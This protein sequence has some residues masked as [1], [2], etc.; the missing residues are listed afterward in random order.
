MQMQADKPN[1]PSIPAINLED[2]NL[3]NNV[4]FHSIHKNRRSTIAL[5][6]NTLTHS[7]AHKVKC[8]TEYKI[9]KLN[10]IYKQKKDCNSKG[11]SSDTEA[12]AILVGVV[13][14]LDRPG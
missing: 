11:L 14:F 8:Q 9:C 12:F 3:D 1:V 5:I 4:Q 10:L 13:E 7:K 6:R 2:H